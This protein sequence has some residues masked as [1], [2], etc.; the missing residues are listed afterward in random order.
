MGS[1]D[2]EDRK[3]TDGSLADHELALLNALRDSVMPIEMYYG[4]GAGH[5]REA[6]EVLKQVIADVESGACEGCV[7][8]A[9][10]GAAPDTLEALKDYKEYAW[11]D[12]GRV[13]PKLA[14]AYDAACAPVEAAGPKM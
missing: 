7:M 2:R 6:L 8:D 5:V 10:K 13:I 1:W 3:L 14:K 11:S 4:Y 12:R 9:L